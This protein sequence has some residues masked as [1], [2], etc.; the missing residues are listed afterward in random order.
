MGSSC[1][2]VG[3]LGGTTAGA[4]LWDPIALWTLA[5]VTVVYHIVTMVYD[6]VTMVHH[7]HHGSAKSNT[8][9]LHQS[10]CCHQKDHLQR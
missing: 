6:I 10:V 4:P 7:S 3:T 1:P 2:R 8:G 9:H 5:S